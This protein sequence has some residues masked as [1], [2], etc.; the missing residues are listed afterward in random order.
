MSIRLLCLSPEDKLGLFLSPNYF[1]LS[2][3]PLFLL[4]LTSLK[5]INC[6]DLLRT[7]I[8]AKLGSQNG[9]GQKYLLVSQKSPPSPLCL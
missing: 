1:F 9:L 5:M 6:C 8:M 7:N 2:A 3:F 4:S